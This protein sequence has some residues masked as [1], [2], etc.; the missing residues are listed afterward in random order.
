MSSSGSGSPESVDCVNSSSKLPPLLGR[1]L[2]HPTNE[3]SASSSLSTYNVFSE[4]EKAFFK[5]SEAQRQT[6][7]ANPDKKVNIVSTSEGS[8]VVVKS[9]AEVLA[10]ELSK[11]S[12]DRDAPPKSPLKYDNVPPYRATSSTSGNELEQMGSRTSNQFGVLVPGW[13][14]STGGSHDVPH[15]GQTEGG[16][17]MQFVPVITKGTGAPGRGPTKRKKP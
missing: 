2:L 7:G 15:L 9:S 12:C 17:S 4:Q 14:Y 10:S 6:S 1:D 3:T 11:S 8:S 5:R 16:A 13:G